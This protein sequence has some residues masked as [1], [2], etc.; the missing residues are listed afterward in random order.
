M[1]VKYR[2][3]ARGRDGRGRWR[4]LL[5]ITHG[6]L[7]RGRATAAHGAPRSRGCRGFARNLS[8]I[9]PHLLDATCSASRPSAAPAA[10]CGSGRPTPPVGGPR[11]T[12]RAGPTR[13]R[14]GVAARCAQR[15]RAW[16]ARGAG[17]HTAMNS[18][19]TARGGVRRQA[20]RGPILRLRPARGTRPA[21]GARRPPH[22][23]GDSA[24]PRTPWPLP[25]PPRPCP[26]AGRPAGHPACAAVN[27]ADAEGTTAAVRAAGRGHA[28]VLEAL[29][30]T[31]RADAGARNRWGC[32][33]CIYA[34]S[35]KASPPAAHA[36][37]LARRGGVAGAA[38]RADARWTRA[39]RPEAPPAAG[40]GA[41]RF[42]RRGASGPRRAALTTRSSTCAS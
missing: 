25:R 30:A 15:G 9:H 40:Q 21:R 26:P 28:G 34:G 23:R 32:D 12:E 5:L 27:C 38:A 19:Q 10:T 35:V 22:G 24:G 31:G 6:G 3:G 13:S 14:P 7:A 4:G 37:V 16:A 41:P 39:P 17:C 18:R 8:A 33:L 36:R 2:R 1:W 11:A 20:T 42:K 29:L